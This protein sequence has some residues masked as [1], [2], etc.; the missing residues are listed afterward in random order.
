MA[1]AYSLFPSLPHVGS[2]LGAENPFDAGQR[3]KDHLPSPYSAGLHN[4]RALVL[5]EVPQTCLLRDKC[6][7]VLLN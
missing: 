7:L 3:L 4:T 2:V 5:K 6:V 1:G